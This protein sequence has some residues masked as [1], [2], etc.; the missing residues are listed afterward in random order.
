MP[1]KKSAAK[2]APKAKL[3][4]PVEFGKNYHTAQIYSK[5]FEFAFMTDQEG[6]YKQACTFVHCKDFLHDA[7]WAMVNQKPWSIYGFKYTPGKDLPL[8]LENC[9]LAF[10]NT[11]YKA[12][13]AEFHAQLE[14][15]QTFLNGI[16]KK[17]K[18][19]K[20]LFFQVEHDGAPCWLIVGDKKWQHAPP[21]LGLFTLFIRL[22]FFHN[23]EQT[24][25]QTL[26][27]AYAGKIKIGD[28]S[29]YAGNNDCSY[30]K[31]AR[32]AVELMLSLGTKVFH[33]KMVD[34]YPQS[35]N[36]GDISLHDDVGPV[37]F[38][39]GACK[40]VMP[41]WFRDKVWKKEKSASK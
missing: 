16:E 6:T 1:A 26:T 27:S 39:E 22:G 2:K 17:M 14:A 30:L 9:V 38:A 28:D 15:C 34:N 32:R 7:M 12:K 8:D 4:P 19:K 35:L 36:D 13:P 37:S 10:R 23:L 21:L 41:F 33:P 11:Q 40:S 3:A 20:S 24:V 18:F 25:D 31:Q 29:N 5:G